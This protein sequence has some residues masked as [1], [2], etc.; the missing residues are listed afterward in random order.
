MCGR[1]V[2]K[3]EPKKVAQNLGAV[4]GEENWTESYNA[5]PSAIIPIV[6]ADSSGRSMVPAVWGFTSSGRGPLFNARAETVDTLPSFRD[7]FRVNRCLIPASGFYEWRPSDRQPF[8]FEMVNGH[9]LTFAG[10]WKQVGNHLQATVIT[11]KPNTDMGGVHDRMPVILSPD[12][13]TSWLSATPIPDN[14]RR[15]LPSPSTDGTLSRWPVG[16]GVGIIRN[17]YPGL[18]DPVEPPAIAQ[19]LF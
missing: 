9:P 11:T 16:R 1:F 6:T 19:E 12:T 18:I 5:A 17:D 7:A 3:G 4:A 10:I 14:L 8:Y 2:R 13:W 15:R